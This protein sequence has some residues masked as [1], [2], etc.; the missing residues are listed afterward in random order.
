MPARLYQQ[1]RQ[2]MSWCTSKQDA[3]WLYGKDER[4]GFKD[5]EHLT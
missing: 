4:E 3:V 5:T 2:R 1:K